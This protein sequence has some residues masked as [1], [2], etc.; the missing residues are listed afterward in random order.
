MSH[1][2]TGWE[3]EI[4]ANGD[5]L[6]IAV[7]GAGAVGVTAAHDLATTGATVTVYE[8]GAIGSGSSGRAAGVL[9]DAF[10][11]D[12]DAQIGARTQERVRSLSGVDPFAF[13]D[14]PY[15]MVAHKTDT[16]RCEALAECVERMR[17]HGRDVSRIEPATLGSQ[18]PLKTDDIGV[19]AVSRNAG[20]TT[21]QTYVDAVAKRAV[22]RGV[23]LKTETTAS[24]ADAEDTT[25]I[26]A[27]GERTTY[28][29][30]IIAAGAHTKQL[31]GAVGITIAMK[32]YRVQALTS[33]VP[34]NG[35]MCYDATTGVYFRPHPTGMLAGD[36]TE[37]VETDPDQWERDADTW[38]IDSVT[39]AVKQRAAYEITVDRAWAGLCTATPDENPLC[40][41]LRDGLYVA[42]GWQG[43]GFMRAAGMGEAIAKDVLG[44]PSIEPFDPTRFTGEESF[45]ITEGMAVE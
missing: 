44:E 1:A 45:E 38:F 31:L 7:I 19:A 28:D 2:R 3:P 26:I 27:N 22:D 25:T 30:V 37:L 36:G 8:K 43:H 11:T 16:K 9:Y 12:V 13:T 33:T 24:I 6:A 10:A 4:D 18:F 29:R 34:Y 42:T 35:P 32:P 15:I 20:W 17:V 5:G 39:D 23:K 41:E 21:P 40:G 14:C